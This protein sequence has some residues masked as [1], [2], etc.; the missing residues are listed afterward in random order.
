MIVVLDN[1]ANI[2]S[3]YIELLKQRCPERGEAVKREL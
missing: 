2:T 3:L 1:V